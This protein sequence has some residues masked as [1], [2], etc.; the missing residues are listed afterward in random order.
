MDSNYFALLIAVIIVVK[1]CILLTRKKII[2]KKEYIIIWVIT[3]ILFILARNINVYSSIPPY[4]LILLVPIPL[5]LLRTENGAHYLY[6]VN[7]KMVYVILTM[8]LQ[9][10]D[11][12][13]VEKGNTVVLKEF[14]DKEITF[15]KPSSDHVEISLKE[16]RN[17]P[18]YEEIKEELKARIKKNDEVVFPRTG[19]TYLIIGIAFIILTYV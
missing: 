15:K 2:V 16:I 11:I 17:L 9:E 5:V 18:L 1:G 8:L 19:V 4:G 3:L 13:Y 12:D 14:D 10:K 6:N 7:H